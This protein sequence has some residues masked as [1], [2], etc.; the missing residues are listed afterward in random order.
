MTAG[1]WEQMPYACAASVAMRQYKGRSRNKSGVAEFLDEVRT[2]H[3][4]VHVGAT[5]P[6]EL[7]AAALKGEHDEASELQWR[8][9]VTAAAATGVVSSTKTKR[10]GLHESFTITTA[11]KSGTFH[12]DAM[13]QKHQSYA[14]N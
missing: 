1:K 3:A 4:R 5:M 12:T 10:L 7:V 2:G 6:H 13:H 8:R 11:M 14:K 9:A